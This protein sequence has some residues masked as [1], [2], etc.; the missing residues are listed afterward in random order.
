MAKI[1]FAKF[2]L[3]QA[4]RH[5]AY[6][7]GGIVVDVDA[8]FANPEEWF[9]AIP[10]PRRPRRDQPF[11][12]IL[13][14]HEGVDTVTYVSEQNLLSDDEGLFAPPSEALGSVRADP[15]GFAALTH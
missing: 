3:G 10:E 1:V 2:N 4:V 11:Y 8:V 6:D 13:V 7:F 15:A 5:R 14:H 9:E 12:R